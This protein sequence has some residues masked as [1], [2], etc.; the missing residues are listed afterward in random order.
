[1]ASPNSNE[2]YDFALFEPKRQHEEP[3]KKSNIIELPKEKLEQNR[4][5]KLNPFRVVSTFLAFGIMISIVGTMVYGQVQLTELT[6]NL[7]AATKTL[8]ESESVYTQLQ[9][10]SDSQLSLQT[11]ENYATNKL[12]LKKIEQNQVEPIAL[13]KGDKTQVV[14]NSGDD[15]WLTSLWNSILQL[16]S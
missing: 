16:L 9:M 6:E 4:R 14:Q 10:K 13:S 3:Q 5:V 8:N 7:N 11:V 1:M 15:N 12:G 2:A